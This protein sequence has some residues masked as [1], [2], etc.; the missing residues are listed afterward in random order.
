MGYTGGIIM[1]II[2][3]IIATIQWEY[4]IITRIIVVMVAIVIIEIIRTNSND[5]NHN[6][7]NS[8]SH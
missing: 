3:A 6:I 8:N 4:N 2:M 1:T 5:N 7:K